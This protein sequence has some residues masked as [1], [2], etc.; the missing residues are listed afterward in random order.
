MYLHAADQKDN[1]YHLE[2]Y[3][4]T[5]SQ[6]QSNPLGS[7]RELRFQRSV[8]HLLATSVLPRNGEWDYARTLIDHSELLTEEERGMVRQQLNDVEELSKGKQDAKQENGDSGRLPVEPTKVTG[9]WQHQQ[10]KGAS[11]QQEANE[12]AEVPTVLSKPPHHR[13]DSEKDFGIED[14]RSSALPPQPTPKSSLKP[15]SRPLRPQHPGSSPIKPSKQPAASPS[16]LKR[17]AAL[18]DNLQRLITSLS[19]SAFRNPMALLRFILF[20]IG[21]VVALSRRDVKE[22]LRQAWEKVQRTVGMGVKVS[23][24]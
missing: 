18:M 7:S 14:S 6:V 4:S 5:S 2:T 21:I 15:S 8:I 11:H 17:G 1:Q 9:A 22:R 3:L 12:E 23:Y 13:H 20:L 10:A 19:H 16:I 24:I